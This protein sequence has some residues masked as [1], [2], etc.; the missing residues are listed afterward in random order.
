MRAW[1]PF[2]GTFKEASISTRTSP[3][4]QTGDFDA[5]QTFPTAIAVG[6]LSGGT[7][8]DIIVTNNDG[9]G[10]I[11]VLLPAARP[12]V[13]AVPKST[14]F[15]VTVNV[16]NPQAI[17]NLTVNLALTYPNLQELS[18]QL[19][20]PDGEHITLFKNQS[21]PGTAPAITSQGLP[22]GAA[23]GVFGFAPPTAFGL[24]IGTVFDDNAT[25][26][27]FDPTTH[28]HQWQRRPVYRPLQS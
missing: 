13:A 26:N 7:W 9:R 11:S 20:A 1:S 12:P 4:G 10:T 5:G 23:L 24:D 19:V 22:G 8:N 25:R 28:R 27:I 6:N 17:T 18:L 15:T 3:V 21:P 16:P 2:S 14:T